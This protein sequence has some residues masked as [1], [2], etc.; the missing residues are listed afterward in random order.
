MGA[1]IDHLRADLHVTVIRD[2]VDARGAAHAAGEQAVLRRLDLNWSTFD[3]EIEWERNGVRETLHFRHGAKDGPRNGRMREYFEVGEHMPEPRTRPAQ[4]APDT[5]AESI[6]VRIARRGPAISLPS[7]SGRQLPAD[8]SL[9]ER[10][11]ACA[12]EPEFHRWVLM[13]PRHLHVGACL[14][15]GTVT[16]TKMVGDDGRFHG[17]AWHAYLTVAVS[18]EIL[19]WLARWPRVKVTR[20][21]HVRWPMA[22]ELV[23]RDVLYYPAD[24]RC[25]THSEL[26]KL[27]DALE[28]EQHSLTPG[29]RLRDLVARLGPPPASLPE[30]LSDFA[31]VWDALQVAPESDLATL[32]FTAQLRHRASNVGVDL[33]RRRPDVFEVMVEALRSED[34]VWQ[35]A[36]HALAR[37]WRPVDPRM[38]SVL[39]ELLPTLSLAPLP[40]VPGR[41]VSCARYEALFV[42]IADLH[43]ATPAMFAALKQLK[44][45]LLR[46]DLSLVRSLQIV[47]QGLKE[48]GGDG[49]GAWSRKT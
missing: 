18:D 34:P 6:P 26:A 17:N 35:S 38:A 9:E 24:V 13:E 44:L 8:T 40:D 49:C 32:L 21:D 25:E 20:R 33:L 15:C 4:A 16:V 5:A 43:V 7:T 3:L 23:E 1:T 46:H 12:C 10:W 31:Q 41:I 47:E 11:V 48:S 2:F 19:A 27:E 22:D 30:S 39:I 29:E 37:A 14:R 42:L 36:G 28:R 45:R